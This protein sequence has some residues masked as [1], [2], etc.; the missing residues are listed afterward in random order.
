VSTHIVDVNG[1]SYIIYG[2]TVYHRLIH[3]IY[4]I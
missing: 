3:V 1:M 2:M 4:P